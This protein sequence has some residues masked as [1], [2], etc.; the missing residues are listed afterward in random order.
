MHEKA[1]RPGRP[2][3][4][5][6]PGVANGEFA[7]QLMNDGQLRRGVEAGHDVAHTLGRRHAGAF[8]TAGGIT[9]RKARKVDRRIGAT[10]VA[11]RIAAAL[12]ARI[13][14]IG[15]AR[16][17]ITKL[18]QDIRKFV[19]RV[20]AHARGCVALD[21]TGRWLA[22]RH[23]VGIAIASAGDLDAGDA[24]HRKDMV[25]RMVL[26]HQHENIRDRRHG[27]IIAARGF[28][29]GHGLP[30]KVRA[31]SV[32]LPTAPCKRNRAISE[33]KAEPF[34]RTSCAPEG[35]RTPP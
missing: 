11:V 8:G 5:R 1:V 31:R 2:R 3:Q 20:G 32:V 13:A 4:G 26:E 19:P 16:R 17:H 10:L 27:A 23:R 14:I 30:D 34:R 18:Q 9:L 15:G 7:R 28:V 24:R 6:E 25:E 12:L 22:A 21:A 33:R 29:L 35:A